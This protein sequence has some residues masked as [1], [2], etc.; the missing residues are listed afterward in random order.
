[1][2]PTMN[3]FQVA[4]EIFEKMPNACFGVVV[5]RGIDNQKAYPAISDFYQK[6]QEELFEKLAG[7]KAKEYPPITPY[8]EAF[9]KLEINPNK[10]P[11]SIEALSSRIE[12]GK[13]IPS[14]NPIVDLGNAISLKYG[15]PLGAHDLD[16]ATAPLEVRLSHPDDQFVPFG[17]TSPETIDSGEILYVSG[18]QVKTRRWIWRQSEFGKITTHSTNI[19]FPLD[20]FEDINGSDTK[21]ARDELATL[22]EHHFEVKPFVGWVNKENPTCSF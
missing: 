22:L 1:M 21:E 18:H 3:Q 13:W 20:G 4:P 12:K 2:R 6:I 15:I 8:R 5:I 7:R 10:F 16:S 11:P 17:A 19:F 14:I 9:Q